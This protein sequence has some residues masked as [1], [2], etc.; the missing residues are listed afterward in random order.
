MTNVSF[1]KEYAEG[2]KDHQ[3]LIF[4]LL[5]LFTFAKMVAYSALWQKYKNENMPKN[6]CC[7]LSQGKGTVQHKVNAH[8]EYLR[9]LHGKR[10]Q[11]MCI[12]GAT[13]GAMYNV[14]CA[15]RSY[16]WWVH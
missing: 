3:G 16:F 7:S 4:Q 12:H 15:Y 9:K 14:Q 13:S 6:S 1:G 11:F 2:G 8:K 10:I 5:H